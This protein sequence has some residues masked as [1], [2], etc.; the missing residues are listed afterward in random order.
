M[1]TA[2]GF[3]F[4]PKQR[5]LQRLPSQA[6]EWLAGRVTDRLVVINDADYESALRLRLVAR[7]R[8]EKMPGIGLD[9]G[10]YDRSSDLLAEAEILRRDIGVPKD[11][12]LF[13]MI[14]EMTPRK[15][16]RDA[17]QAFA[18]MNHGGAHLALAGQGPLESAIV[19]QSQ[20]LGIAHRV[21]LLSQ[22][23][24]VRPLILASQATLLPSLRE[25]MARAVME[26]LAL[27]VPVVGTNIRGIADTVG[28]DGGILVSLHDVVAIASALDSLS[29]APPLDAR[30]RDEIRSRIE[31]Y[32][33]G[34]IIAQ[35]E[36]MYGELLEELAGR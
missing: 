31:P 15:G 11:Q 14:A 36:R 27:G 28:D 20:D 35:H 13:T 4:T 22:V 7:D 34:N 1:Y 8:L 6:V 33:I 16:H 5:W 17:L 10:W 3:H 25:G 30:Q 2:H 29:T 18:I 19:Q 26:S 23:S 24:D 32:A 21:H 9:F 12:P